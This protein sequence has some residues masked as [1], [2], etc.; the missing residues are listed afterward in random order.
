M[1]RRQRI[2]NEIDRMMSRFLYYDRKE[3]DELPVG[4]IEEAIRNREITRS[5]ILL[6]INEVLTK[7]IEGG[8]TND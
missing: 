7:A 6:V 1:E 5:E 3:D 4:A 8:E 2:L